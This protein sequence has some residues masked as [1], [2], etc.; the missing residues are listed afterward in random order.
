MVCGSDDGW[1][2]LWDAQPPASAKGARLPP[3]LVLHNL[4]A[5]GMQQALRGQ[6]LASSAVVLM[7]RSFGPAL[8]LGRWSQVHS[9]VD[10]RAPRTSLLS[11]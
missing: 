1:V 6:R 11:S 4:A 9:E 3:L 7:C 10:I 8:A 5:V 2:Y